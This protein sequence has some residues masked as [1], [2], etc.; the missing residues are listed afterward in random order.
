MAT[1]GAW[2]L[3]GLYA[4]AD[5]E[6]QVD[7]GSLKFELTGGEPAAHNWGGALG[8][9]DFSISAGD[10]VRE[11]HFGVE[12]SDAAHWLGL[13]AQ[14]KIALLP[15]HQAMIRVGLR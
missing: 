14:P 7:H 1:L 12:G 2:N 11:F 3:A 15:C 4:R 8:I 6:D 9:A 5:A 10:E 13:A